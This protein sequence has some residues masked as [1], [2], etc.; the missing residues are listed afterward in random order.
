MRDENIILPLRKDMPGLLRLHRSVER[1]ASWCSWKCPLA[2]FFLI[3]AGNIFPTPAWWQAT[4]YI[5]VAFLIA[6]LFCSYGLAIAAGAVL[7]ERPHT[8]FEAVGRLAG[9]FGGVAFAA[10]GLVGAWALVKSGI[11]GL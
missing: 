7:V 4:W 9:V 3:I 5:A 11:S 6:L 10:I 8:R 2:A 1:L